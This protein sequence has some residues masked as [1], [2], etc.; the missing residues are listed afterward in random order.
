MM[1]DVKL[2]Y[3]TG[4]RASMLAVMSL[5]MEMQQAFYY[6]KKFLR[7]KTRKQSLTNTLVLEMRRAGLQVRVIRENDTK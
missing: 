3:G 5:L 6:S 7:V 1:Q 2:I 4:K